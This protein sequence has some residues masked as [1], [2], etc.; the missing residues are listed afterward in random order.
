MDEHEIIQRCIAGHEKGW[1]EFLACYGGSIY[2]AICH[3]LRRF[4]IHEPEVAEDVFAQV[5]EKLLVND[6]K[7]LRNFQWKSKLTTWLISV[8]RN[9]TYDYLRDRKRKPEIS[10][11]SLVD[12]DAHRIEEVLASA[13]DLDHQMEVQL[14]VTEA[15]SWLPT[16]ARLILQLYYIEGMKEREIAELL[17]LSVDAVSARKSRALQKLR[18][19]VRKR[20]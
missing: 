18:K 8:A 13:L 3:V 1:K 5:I 11:S 15:L 12:E 14:T 16:K 7:A 20:P 2:G 4:S 19:M 9:K 6:C 17:N 10:L